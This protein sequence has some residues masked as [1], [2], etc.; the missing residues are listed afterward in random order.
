MIAH[1]EIISVSPIDRKTVTVAGL[2]DDLDR[3]D[4]PQIWVREYW[5]SP[6]DLRLID[7]L[8][9]HP[10]LRDHVRLSHEMNSQKRW[11][12]AEG[13]QPVGPND[14]SRNAKKLRLPSRRFIDAKSPEVDLFLLESDCLQLASNEIIVREKSNTN[15]DIYK[16]PH[17]LITKGFKRIAFADFS[18]SFRHALRGIHGPKED[19]SLLI[20]LAAYLRSPLAQYFAFH[21]S[22]NRSMFHE[23]VQ[24][25]ELLRLPFPLPYQLPDKDRSQAIVDQVAGIVDNASD[26]ARQHFLG[27]TNI[28]EAATEKIAPLIAE[29]FELEP[30]EADLVR[31][32]VEVT[33]PSIQRSVSGMPVPTVKPSPTDQ[34]Q[35]YVDRVCNMLNSWAARSRYCVRGTVASSAT[36]GIGIAKFDKVLKTEAQQPLEK[37]DRHLL[38]T[39]DRLRTVM[40]ARQRAIDPIRELM[41]FD[42]NQL[43]L[44]KPVEQRHWTQTAALNDADEVAGTILMHSLKETA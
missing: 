41:V 32:A 3:I 36:L 7:R 24:V 22:A 18:V 35:A 10:R 34:Q 23:E 25:N 5:G 12:R 4:A 8:S 2:F 29:Y 11:V 37:I 42:N 33:I 31:D 27:R 20:F 6:R 28:V 21:T 13:F 30:S 17:V 14:D 9:L 40:P 38:E 15:T 26:Q 19:R 44:I 43:Y 1:A 39:F 16:A